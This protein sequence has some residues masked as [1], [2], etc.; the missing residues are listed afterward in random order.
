MFDI[1]LAK[2]IR[3]GNR[4]VQVGMD[5]YNAFNSDAIQSYETDFDPTNQQW[6]APRSVVQPRV[7]RFSLQFSF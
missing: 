3:F 5:L 2:N 4:R 7:A 6:L 1:K